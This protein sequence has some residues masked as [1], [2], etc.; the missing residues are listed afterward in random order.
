MAMAYRHLLD[1][2]LSFAQKALV[3]TELE[4]RK[5]RHEPSELLARAVQPILWLVVFGGVFTQVRIIPTGEL[6]YLDFLTPGILAQSVL[7]ISIFYGISMIWERDMGISQKF[8]TSPAPRTALVAGRALAAGIRGLTQA[9]VVYIVAL[10]LGVK[11]N[12]DPLSILLVIVV[13]L[14]G[15]AIFSSLSMTIAALARTRER[16]MGIGQ[17]MSMPLFFA[18]NAIY[19]ISL[20][21]SWLQAIAH[22]NP[23]TY[24]V[25]ALRQTMV[26]GGTGLYSV[27][28]DIAVMLVICVVMILIAGRLYPRVAI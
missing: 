7:F 25:D 26:V 24:Q 18:S 10:L 5:I 11:M 3:M 1:A 27:G 2:P 28:L 22:L 20:M 21:P 9:A 6:G 19:P 8:L 16:F 17:L 12:L 13:L 15:G 14:L 23:L 4:V